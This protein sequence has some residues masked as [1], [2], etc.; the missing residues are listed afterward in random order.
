[1]K[2]LLV[3]TILFVTVFASDVFGQWMDGGKLNVWTSRKISRRNDASQETAYL[4][5]VRVA[6]NKGFDRVVFEFIG[7]I[8]RYQI[9]YVKPPIVGTADEEIKVSGKFFVDINLQMLPYPED[10]N[11]PDAK[12]PEGKLNLPVIMEVKEIEWFE[13]VRPFVVGLK[14]KKLYRVSQL[15][16]PTRLV[17][18]FKH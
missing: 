12:I 3:L 9:Q 10:E 4:K 6:K 13:G 2:K 8:P 1:M 17:I 15:K 18:D 5:E 11:F 14:A 7:D 16:N